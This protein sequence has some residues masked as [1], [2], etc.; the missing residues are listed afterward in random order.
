MPLDSTGSND[1]APNT[2]PD[3]SHD[4]DAHD[5]DL[6]SHPFHLSDALRTLRASG[7]LA[8]PRTG[9]D[10]APDDALGHAAD[11]EA[12]D[13]V[14]QALAHDSREVAAGS[15]FVAIRGGQ[16]DGHRFLEQA[17]KQGAA[18]LVVD[19][20]YDEQAVPPSALE[21]GH[22]AASGGRGGRQRAA[23]VTVRDTRAALAELAAAF[24]RHPSRELALLGVTGT[25]GKTTVTSL[26]HAALAHMGDAAGLIGTVEVR[27]GEEKISATHTTPD[28]LALSRL[29]R[30]M[31]DAGCPSCAMEVSSHALDQGRVRAQRFA[32]AAFT[33]LT[34]DHLDYHETFADY[35][36]AKKRLFD[37]LDASAT[38]IVNRD[39][40]AWNEM[41]ADSAATIVTYGQ[42]E[43][44]DLRVEILEN[45]PAG[46]RLRLDGDERRYRLAG[47]FNAYNLAAAYGLLR[48]LGKGKEESLAALA[49]APPP[50]G[51]F[52]SIEAADGRLALVDYAHTPD[53]LK[54]VL[55]AARPLVAEGKRLHVLFG[56]GGD[57]DRTKRPEMAAVAEAAADR[58]WI[59]S[60]NPRSEDPAA[61]LHEITAGLSPRAD[62]EAVLDRQLAIDVACADLQVGDVLVVAG[63]GHETYQEVQGHRRPFDDRE[64]VRR[65][66]ERSARKPPRTDALPADLPPTA[67]S[68]S[69]SATDPRAPRL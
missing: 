4:H 17:E 58:L 1:S 31:A 16:A 43:E 52:E 10:P 48:A 8:E 45:A 7:L 42:G 67:E 53:A 22:P 59:T 64:H 54:N 19:T 63:K 68:S 37:G 20:N 60:D 39:D 47:P 2:Q 9:R 62:V 51:R 29:L 36:A 56:C 69:R 3:A 34:H 21:E 15:L 33:N 61:I 55:E 57:R 38:A 14:I 13:P 66:F 44:A 26:V 30:Q 27:I 46:L 32:A 25:N 41:V 65:A 28:A 18:A 12:A 5:H 49:Q 11:S 6:Q 24:Y 35:L 40:A 23:R 50:P